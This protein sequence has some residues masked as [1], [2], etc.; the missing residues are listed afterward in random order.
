M[1]ASPAN[2]GT[3]AWRISAAPCN[4]NWG[5]ASVTPSDHGP[6]NNINARQRFIPSW[7]GS[8]TRNARFHAVMRAFLG[9]IVAITV[10]SIGAAAANARGMEL[11]GYLENWVDVKWWDNNMPGNCY[12]G[13]F[14]PDAY[15]KSTTPYSALNYGEYPCLIVV[16]Y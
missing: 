11:L 16:V 9:G 14:E 15:I 1:G 2:A 13:C 8:C 5:A 7:S 10:L 4:C 12:Q 3:A 6:S